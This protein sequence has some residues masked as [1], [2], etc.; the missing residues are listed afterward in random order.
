MHMLS[1]EKLW[2]RVEEPMSILAYELDIDFSSTSAVEQH[3]TQ[4]GSITVT[5]CYSGEQL[6]IC[7]I[8]IST[9]RGGV[10]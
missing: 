5:A 10:F 1:V 2:C 9:I 7:E 3:R 6:T 4:I 8:E